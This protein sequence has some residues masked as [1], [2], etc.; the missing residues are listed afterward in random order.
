MSAGVRTTHQTGIDRL[1]PTQRPSGRPIGYQSWSQLLFVHWRLPAAI[2][3]PLIPAELE[4]DTWDGDAWVGLVPFAMSGVRPWWFPA[5][6]GVSNFLETNVRTYVHLRGR[7]PGVW[8]FSL[9]ASNSLAVRVARWRWHLPYFRA[10]MSL[11][12]QQQTIRYGSQ[13]LWPGPSGA[14]C[15]IH[16]EIGPLWGEQESGRARPAG[17]ALP[18]TFEHFLV[19]RY[20]LYSTDAAQRLYSGRVFHAPYSVRSARLLDFQ[21][22]L[23]PASGITPAEAPSHVAFSEGVDV[24]I[25]PLRPTGIEDSSR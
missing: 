17:Q 23:L 11:F 9:E 15:E 22:S 16:A 19:E 5:V 14:G 20:I 18:G 1:S 8:F 4:I 12:R 25:F 7:A 2:L 13:R 21:E 6:P 3:R 24:E 10:Q